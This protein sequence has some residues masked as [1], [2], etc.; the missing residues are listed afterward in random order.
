MN[1]LY[2]VILSLDNRIKLKNRIG[3]YFAHFGLAIFILGA[4]VSENNKIE[5]ELV[6]NVGETKTIGL[7]DYKLE[8]LREL[9][10]VNYDAIIASVLV[11]KNNQFITEINP[12]K[13]L[14]HSSESPMTEAGIHG[15]IERD[16]YVS[17][18]NMVD[19]NKWSLRIYDKPFIRFIWIGTIFMVIGSIFSIRFKKKSL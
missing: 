4:S 2:D 12:E 7:F 15:R 13:R 14:Y 16:L 10:S 3:M 5:K 19:D 9:K 6:L 17:L 11:S 1:I 8:K 18:G